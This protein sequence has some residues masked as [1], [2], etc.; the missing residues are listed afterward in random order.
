VFDAPVG[1]GA[2][3]IGRLGLRFISATSEVLWSCHWSGT[4]VG[5][6]IGTT[7]EIGSEGLCST[8]KA[9]SEGYAYGVFKVGD[10]LEL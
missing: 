5:S 2:G 6:F 7:A 8:D 9:G 1:G 4:E 3:S 10:R